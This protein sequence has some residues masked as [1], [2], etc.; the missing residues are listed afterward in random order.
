MECTAIHCDALSFNLTKRTL[1]AY[2]GAFTGI[3]DRVMD[4]ICKQVCLM[5]PI[6]PSCNF[7]W[8]KCDCATS[9]LNHFPKPVELEVNLSSA[10][11]FY[12]GSRHNCNNNCNSNR[13]WIQIQTC[14]HHWTLSRWL[15]PTQA[16]EVD[17]LNY[18]IRRLW[19]F[20]HTESLFGMRNQSTLTTYQDP[21]IPYPLGPLY[22]VYLAWGTSLMLGISATSS[23]LIFPKSP[24]NSL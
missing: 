13:I 14:V 8:P 23:P 7:T 11:S 6:K 21:L 2:I 5:Q 9:S 18:R 15:N 3:P 4:S 10:T 20:Q 17:S 1:A 19:N 24:I 22:L 16:I 12:S